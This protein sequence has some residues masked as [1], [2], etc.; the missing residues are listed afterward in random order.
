AAGLE[1]GL[2]FGLGFQIGDWLGWGNLDNVFLGAMLSISSTTI[3]LKT[4]SEL[5]LTRE[6]FAE[7]VFG[8]LIVEDILAIAILALLSSIA[9]TGTFEAGTA[10]ATLTRLAIFLAALLV[11][12][13]L[14]V[15]P[16]LAFVARTHSNEMV[17]VSAL[18]LCFGVALLA[19]QLG[20]SV[21]L[22][23]F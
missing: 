16:L 15:P 10:I 1:I 20:Y 21:A 14:V 5:G 11:V 23:A 2:M 19:A 17:L 12:G 4:L 18:G 22:G 7:L 3:I 9:M 8:I 6:H 13:L